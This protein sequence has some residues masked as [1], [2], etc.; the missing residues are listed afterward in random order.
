MRSA[1]L[2]R[3]RRAGLPAPQANPPRAPVS[4]PRTRFSNARSI[5]MIGVC[6]LANSL[7]TGLTTARQLSSL[8]C[9]AGLQTLTLIARAPP[10]RAQRLAISFATPHDSQHGNQVD[11]SSPA[12]ELLL[13]SLVSALWLVP[14]HREEFGNSRTP[15]RLSRKPESVFESPANRGLVDFLRERTL[16]TV[17]PVNRL[18]A[19]ERMPKYLHSSRTGA[20]PQEIKS[21]DLILEHTVMAGLPT[22]LTTACQLA[23]CYCQPGFTGPPTNHT[24]ATRKRRQLDIHEPPCRSSATA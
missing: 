22:G 18:R 23:G 20:A 16:V 13:S 5:R 2:K 9:Q 7:T 15:S 10:G 14:K 8:C 19:T 6:E 11:N 21:P 3:S 24:E 12:G 17:K 4:T 1:G